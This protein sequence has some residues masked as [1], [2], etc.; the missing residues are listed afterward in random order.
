[1]KN[2]KRPVRSLIVV[3]RLFCLLTVFI[4]CAALAVMGI[5]FLILPKSETS[6][7]EKRKIASFPKFTASD[8]LSG[9]Y[10]Q[11]ISVYC[12][13]NFAF[14]DNLVK[15]SFDLED[16]RGIRY[17]DVKIYGTDKMQD[18][19]D[20][21]P[22]ILSIDEALEKTAASRP[23]SPSLKIG[24]EQ[25]PVK[26]VQTVIT[27]ESEY[28]DLTKAD[29]EGEKRG[30]LYMIGD[31]ALEIFYGNENVATDYANTV[32]SFR[33]ALPASV[34]V[35]DMVVPTHFEFG[36]PSKY[37][38]TVGRREKPFIDGIYSKL[39][40]NITAVDAYSE[41]AKHY[42]LGEYLYFRSDHHW[43]GLGAY[44]A[45]TQFIKSAGF[46]PVP[47]ANY[48]TGRIDKFLGTFYT[49]TYDKN[50]EAN[51][52]YID[53]YLP[54]TDYDMVNYKSDGVTTYKGKMIYTKIGTVTDGYLAFMGGDVPCSV[55]TT[56]NS[57]GRSIIIFK[58]SYGNAFIPF[59]LPHYDKIYVADIRSFPFN[60]VN[61]ITENGITDVLF[62]NNIM[63]SC[64]PARVMN[65]M[66][67]AAD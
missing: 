9:K 49:S 11:D 48:Q 3:N 32:N 27:N 20:D 51:P 29:L 23:D 2:N 59:L 55:T 28:A 36:L 12:S 62:L 64:T 53:Y 67:L 26:P 65:I 18:V 6:E 61:Y 4:F 30:A 19:S 10:M 16:Y 7:V 25:V 54:Y 50:L 43:T 5:L 38:K 1:M 47:I 37:L 57:S 42:N 63:T 46:E 66:N 15:L 17:D 34:R 56:G 60:A 24:E 52:D 39:D 35:Y 58:E 44:Y 31:T 14:R 8:F 33:Y 13:D 22:E 40:A 21:S 45:Y 41:I